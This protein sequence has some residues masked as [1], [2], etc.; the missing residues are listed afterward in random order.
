MHNRHNHHG[1]GPRGHHERS[2]HEEHGWGEEH[3]HGWGD[4]P[5]RGRGPFGR[6]GPFMFGPGRRGRPD[7]PF[8]PFGPFGDDPFGGGPFGGGPPRRQRRGDIRFALLE[9]LA[10]QPRHGYDLIK[11]LERRFGGF[12]RPSPGSVYPT[13]QLLEDE[14][15]LTSET[16]EGKRVYTIT[17]SGRKLLAEREPAHHGPGRPP[18]GPMG[19]REE[20]GELRRSAGAL[21]E[22]VMQAARH[23][24]PEQVRAVMQ[25]LERARREV[26]GTL[27]SSEQSPPAE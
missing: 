15:H 22:V 9:L 24:T 16:V 13:L 23:G 25:I 6:G 26:Y 1:R 7:G 8:G 2:H 10:E 11:E 18:F 20:L 3:G 27:A 21:F 19:G 4:D 17:E 12:Y 14:G 5:R